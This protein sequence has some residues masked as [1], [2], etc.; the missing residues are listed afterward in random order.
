MERPLEHLSLPAHDFF[1]PQPHNNASVFLLK[2]II[3]D[4]SDEFCVKLLARLREAATKDTV[5]LLI[6][7]IMPFACHDSQGDDNYEIPGAV[8]HEAPA[9]L[10]A[11]YGH[12][13]LMGY[14]ADIDV[15]IS[16]PFEI[17]HT[18]ICW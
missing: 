8:P 5:L 12:T 6:E 9:P 2:I 14:N 3:H 1:K 16:P 4:W 17:R 7:S 13:N 10:L 18:L 15:W 11:N